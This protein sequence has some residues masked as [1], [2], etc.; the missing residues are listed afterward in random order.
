MSR[1]WAILRINGKIRS[2]I[3]GSVIGRMAKPASELATHE[4]LQTQSGL[5]ELIEVDFEGLS[6]SN[7]YRASDALVK[8]REAL[9]EH[10]FGRA[11]DLFDLKETVTLF[12]LTNTY[13]EGDMAGNAKAKRGHSKEKRT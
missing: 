8:H 13:F 10:L 7:L 1:N 12:D 3:V 11:R 2:A 9:E 5:G 4:W 6:L